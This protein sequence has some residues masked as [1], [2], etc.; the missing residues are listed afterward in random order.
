MARLRPLLYHSWF[1][2]S[3]LLGIAGT[4]FYDRYTLCKQYLFKYTDEDQAIMWY[5]AHELL[6]GRIHEPCFYGQD[7]NSVMEGWLAAPLIAA[8]I[9]FNVAVPLVTVFLGLFPFLLMALVAWRRGQTLIAATAL[10]LPVLLPVRYGI[11]AGMPRGFITGLAISIIPAV[12]LLPPPPRPWRANG[13]GEMPILDPRRKP[14]WLRRSWPATRYFFAAVLALLA[15]QINPN[16]LV[17]LVPA[18]IYVFFTT[19][20][21]WE[22]WVFGLAGVIVTAP[23]LLYVYQFYYIYH[24]DYVVYLR[25]KV[26]TWSF[27]EFNAYLY[28][29]VAPPYGSSLVLSDLVPIHITGADA[30]LFVVAAFSAVALLLILRLRVAGLAAAFGGALFTIATFGY[31][32]L[33]DGRP[34][35]PVTF[36]Y[37]RMFVA[38]PVLFVWLLFLVNA[39]PWPQFFTPAVIRWAKRGALAG[40]LVAGIF[41]VNE[42]IKMMPAVFRDAVQN[43]Q[44]CQPIPVERVYAVAREVQKV[45]DAQGADFLAVGSEKYFAYLLPALTT[46]ETLNPSFERRTWRLIEE[47]SPRHAKLLLIHIGGGTRV[48]GGPVRLDEEGNFIENLEPVPDNPAPAPP[49]PPTP[50]TPPRTPAPAPSG[51]GALLNL[52]RTPA[53]NNPARSQRG[54]RGNRGDRGPRGT[55]ISEISSG[56]QGGT[57]IVDV[58]EISV[59]A[60]DGRSA[61]SVLDS[62]GEGG[63]RISS[64][65]P[66]PEN[67]HPQP[68]VDRPAWRH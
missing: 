59:I 27:A 3:L 14:R 11:I 9:P 34:S 13:E 12:L 10:I 26:F 61:N 66:T 51:L 35:N 58:P 20:R 68:L 24:P 5:A 39:T 37:S 30:P 52:G 28:R 43:A 41:A 31:D 40:F 46:C 38:L 16:C 44:I 1:Q 17:L 65:E 64:P 4:L 8:H 7:Y 54:N 47:N 21:E 18:A 29:Y 22:F 67:P 42:K 6:N 45:A 32:R 48:G 53:T 33:N 23:Y 60:T 2:T 62:L 49:T 63:P 55:G 25:D 36:S 57:H 50:T 15:I 56:P 19:W